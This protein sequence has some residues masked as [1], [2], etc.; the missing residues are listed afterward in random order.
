[1]V[2]QQV[3]ASD[4]KKSCQYLNKRDPAGKTGSLLFTNLLISNA[5]CS[6]AGVLRPLPIQK[7]LILVYTDN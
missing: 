3:L 7:T 4:H 2:C 1:M 6:R 5:S